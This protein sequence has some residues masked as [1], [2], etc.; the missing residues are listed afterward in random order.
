MKNYDTKFVH[1]FFFVASRSWRPGL[2][3][4]VV[5]I[6]TQPVRNTPF[7]GT[8]ARE[9][10]TTLVFDDSS[11]QAEVADRYRREQAFVVRGQWEIEAFI[12]RRFAQS[13]LVSTDPPKHCMGDSHALGLLVKLPPA[14]RAICTCARSG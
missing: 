13:P 6:R 11:K 2:C 1:P 9:S 14:A 10:G 12:K 4:A 3:E 7:A 5:P 8:I